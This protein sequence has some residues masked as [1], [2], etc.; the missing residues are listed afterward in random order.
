MNKI[1][2]E[3]MKEALIL[4]IIVVTF[5]IVLLVMLKYEN[6]GEKNMPFDLSEMLVV[7]SVDE[8]AKKENPDNM[9]WNLDI[10]QY[11]DIYLKIEKNPD[12]NESAYIEKVVIE[13][14]NIKT[15]EQNH[16]YTYMPNS[17]EGN[18]FAYEDNFIVY[19]DLTY[20]GASQDNNKTLEI[21]NQGGRI[22]FRIVNQGI[23]EYVSNDEGEIA[24]DGT[25]L[26]KIGVSEERLNIKVSF[27]LVIKTNIAN[28]RGKINLDLPSGNILEEGICNLKQTDF[29]GIAFKREK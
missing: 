25:L 24:Y 8:L 22:L 21:G 17:T 7:S 1:I 15:D 29:S 12:F 26:K 9:K 10:N 13:N 18:L 6:E 5:G 23:G 2:K 20:N 28:Y 11:N 19:S 3:K 14:I 4:F 16:V 27:D